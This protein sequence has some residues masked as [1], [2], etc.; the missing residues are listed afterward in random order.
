MHCIFKPFKRNFL[1]KLLLRKCWYIFQ[2]N[3]AEIFLFFVKSFVKS[4]KNG[5]LMSLQID[6]H[7][8]EILKYK[9]F[10]VIVGAKNIY[11]RG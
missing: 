3:I 2:K 8:L 7:F 11:F 6:S 1:G 10:G 9:N 5:T 4:F